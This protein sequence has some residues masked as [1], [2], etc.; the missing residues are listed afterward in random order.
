MDGILKRRCSLRQNQKAT[1]LGPTP[2]TLMG[3]VINLLRDNEGAI[4]DLTG[5]QVNPIP[6][7]HA[8]LSPKPFHPS[9]H[10]CDPSFL[11]RDAYTTSPPFGFSGQCKLQ[12]VGM[13][14]LQG[15]GKRGDCRGTRD[16]VG[17]E[18]DA[19]RQKVYWLVAGVRNAKPADPTTEVCFGAEVCKA[20]QGPG[21]SR[22]N[23]E[24]SNSRNKTDWEK[25][26]QAEAKRRGIVITG[27]SIAYMFGESI[28][29]IDR[30]ERGWLAAACIS[31][32]LI[33]AGGIGFIIERRSR[34]RQSPSNLITGAN[35][36][37]P[38]MSPIWTAWAARVA[39]FYRSAAPHYA[40]IHVRGLLSPS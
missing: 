13:L 30:L 19:A 2:L 16:S 24:C 29:G 18:S 6:E 7:S 27:T 12:C 39:Q 25:R 33:I 17:L 5:G 36:G 32:G 21:F 15:F 23:Y 40:N 35:A 10:T 14:G 26:E 28:D 22:A 37:G 38:R 20:S 11:L 34:L 9:R 3:L 4:V 31:G 8:H 1:I